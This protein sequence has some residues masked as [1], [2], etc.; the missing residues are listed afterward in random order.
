MAAMV[1]FSCVPSNLVTTALCPIP[2]ALT[3][4]SIGL[5]V[6]AL[7]ADCAGSCGT[8]VEKR[9]IT[10]V[11]RANSLGP[12]LYIGTFILIPLAFRMSG[13]VCTQEFHRFPITAREFCV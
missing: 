5:A 3:W 4:A 6:A 2:T 11:Q 7:T 1:P 13:T 12:V 8:D 10:A 9:K